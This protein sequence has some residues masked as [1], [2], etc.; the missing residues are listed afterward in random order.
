MNI[1]TTERNASPVRGWRIAGLV[2]ITLLLGGC[3]AMTEQWCKTAEYCEVSP[4]GDTHELDEDLIDYALMVDRMNA[5]MLQ[6]EHERLNGRVRHSECTMDHLRL[7]L[8]SSRLE[9]N[10]SLDDAALDGLQACRDATDIHPAHA[11]L[12]SVL[13]DAHEQLA[14]TSSRMT[15]LEAALD[16][17]RS[18]NAALEEQLEA[19]KAIERS[20]IERGRD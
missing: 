14:G 8:V 10:G 19:L 15:E 17:Q 4:N 11:A 13:H 18:R 1:N 12:A 2:T 7:A 16:E 9:P 6:A 3:Q 20:I 5:T